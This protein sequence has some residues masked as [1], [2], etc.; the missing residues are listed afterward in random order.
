H[1]LLYLCQEV[2]PH[3]LGRKVV[4]GVQASEVRVLPEL[5]PDRKVGIGRLEAVDRVRFAHL[6]PGVDT[7]FPGPELCLVLAETRGEN[8]A[9]QEHLLYLKMNRT[10]LH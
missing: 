1:A 4:N 2:G 8:T 7:P 9:F 10:F 5:V 3:M 6:L